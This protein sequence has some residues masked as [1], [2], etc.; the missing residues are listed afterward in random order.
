MTLET[1][2][3]RVES[4]TPNQIK[5][6]LRRCEEA[7]ER[8]ENMEG[9]KRT[10]VFFDGPFTAYSGRQLREFREKFVRRLWCLGYGWGK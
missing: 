3:N 8:L 10:R 9:P 1:A 2:A 4:L 6:K 5:T 7:L